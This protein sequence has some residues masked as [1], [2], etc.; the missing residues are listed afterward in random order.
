MR[1]GQ[2]PWPGLGL[3]LALVVVIVTMIGLTAGE[4]EGSIW[5]E[6]A[7][8]DLLAPVQNAL[9]RIG[10]GATSL[11]TTARETR[12]LHR[13][14]L[15]LRQEMDRL[16]ELENQVELLRAEK[17]RLESLLEFQEREAAMVTLARV[18]GRRPDNWFNYVVINKGNRHQVEPGQVAVSAQGLV[19]RVSSSSAYSSSIMLLTDPESG[20]GAMVRRSGDTGV[21][22]GMGSLGWLEM[23]MFAWDADILVGDFI[24]TSGLGETYPPGLRIGT[25]TR[26]DIDDRGLVKVARIQP[27]VDFNRLHEIMV[28]EYEADED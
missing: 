22:L 8:S 27:S 2:S 23:R 11:V 18:V 10:A 20:I 28:F 24:V 14:V 13:E 19:G 12:D 17:R 1:Q 26:V 5:P 4:R 25:V 16:G 9:S 15:F 6:R 3:A 7:I 21:V